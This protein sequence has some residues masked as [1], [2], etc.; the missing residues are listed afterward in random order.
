MRDLFEGRGTFGMIRGYVETAT[1]RGGQKLEVE[2]QTTED[3]RQIMTSTTST[4][5]RE[6][7]MVDE[8]KGL[9]VNYF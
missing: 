4:W 1:R 6:A 8:L 7:K 9:N 2:S 5:I 3:R